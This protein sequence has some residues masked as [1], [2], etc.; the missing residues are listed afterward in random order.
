M[1]V[2][3][4]VGGQWCT[5]AGTAEDLFHAVTGEKVAEV[6]SAGL[7]FKGAFEYARN[8][9]GPKLRQMTFHERARMLKSLAKYLTERKE[10]FYKVSYATGAPRYDS[11]LDI[12]GGIGTVFTYASK[13]G[14]D[15]PDETFHV[16]GEPETLS[17]S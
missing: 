5:G 1:R 4:F 16:E 9:G 11:W 3:S 15:S 2:Q 8:I 10:E 17:K 7:D 13:G 14:K 12:D 6:T